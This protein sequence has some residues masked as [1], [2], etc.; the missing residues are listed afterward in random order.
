[1]SLESLERT[2]QQFETLPRDGRI[3]ALIALADRLNALMPSPSE[4]WTVRDIR[5]DLEC[6]D[7]VGLYARSD[8]ERV[9][10]AAEVGQEVT[11]LT[12]ALTALFVEH[13]SGETRAHILNLDSSI[14]PRVV[15]ETLM[16]QRSNGAYYTLRR[17][18]EAV[19]QLEVNPAPVTV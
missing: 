16:R 7:T 10:L 14:V 19:E 4:T 8:G 15:G 2:A 12:R 13:L 9:M 5:Q 18:K 17:L 1:M 11:T 6:Q 3:G